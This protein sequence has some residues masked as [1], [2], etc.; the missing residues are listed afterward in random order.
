MLLQKIILRN[1]DPFEEVIEKWARKNNIE[2]FV[3]D[4]KDSLFELCKSV[5]VFHADHNISREN[6]ELKA[7][8]EKI[9]RPGREID[10]QG[11]MNASISS[12]KFWLENNNPEN[13]LFVGD[14]KLADGTRLEDYLQRLSEE[15]T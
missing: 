10:I 1:S 6:K 13:V 8:M 9:H 12:L 7:Q 5:V 14:D 3:F 11:T 15:L 4:G 2:V